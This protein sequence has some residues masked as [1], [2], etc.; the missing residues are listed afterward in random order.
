M[1]RS[2]RTP[3]ADVA[4]SVDAR[5][6]KSLDFGH[7]GSTPVVRTKGCA[8]AAQKRGVTRENSPPSGK[9]QG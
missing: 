7:T 3:I 6:L 8:R 5:D 1:P 9:K 2:S 4:K